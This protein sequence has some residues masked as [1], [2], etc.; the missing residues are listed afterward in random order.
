MKI[1]FFN[2]E[3]YVNFE[4][5]IGNYELRLLI[6]NCGLVTSYRDY[7]Y[8]R[9]L[10]SEGREAMDRKALQE[11]DDFHPDLVAYSTTWP[12]ESLSP[13]V[14]GEIRK[15]G[16]PVYTHAWDTHIEAAPHEREWFENCSFF[17]VA[18]SITNF[19]HY[20]RLAESQPDIRGCI[21][22]GG[23]N[24]FTDLFTKQDIPKVHDV[25][26]LGSNE[27]QRAELMNYL[28]GK[29]AP[30]GISLS[31]F[32]GLVD[33]TKK[34]PSNRLSDKWVSWER[35]VQIINQSKILLS[36]QTDSARC[37][38]KGKIFQ[39]MACGAFCLCDLNTEINRIIPPNCLVYYDDFE[40][41][42][43][44]MVYYLGH[45]DERRAIAEAAYHWFHSTFGYQKFWSKFLR[46][47]IIGDV[48]LPEPP[49]MDL[50]SRT[51]TKRQHLPVFMQKGS[52]HK[53]GGYLG[54]RSFTP[55]EERMTRS[56]ERRKNPVPSRENQYYEYCLKNHKPYF[57]KVMW[58]LQGVPARHAYMQLLVE[59]LCK[60]RG[61]KPLHIL[62]IGSWAGGSAITWAEAIKKHNQGRGRVVCI[63]PWKLYFRSDQY[64]DLPGDQQRVYQEMSAALSAGQVF[65]LFMHNIRVCKHED[66]ILPFK[67]SSDEILPLFGEGRFDLVFIDGDH[68]Y[69][70]VLEDIR[71][72]SS[73]VVEGGFLCGDDLELQISQADQNHAELNKHKDYILDPRTKVNFHPGVSL[74]VGEIF[75]T[76]SVWEGFWAMRKRGRGW[77]MVDLPKALPGQL[78]IPEH[79][80]CQGPP[81]LMKEDYKGYNIVQY[82]DQYYGLSRTLGPIDLTL[83]EEQI[84]RRHQSA[85]LCV[86]GRFLEE[87]EQMIDQMSVP[88]STNDYFPQGLALM[89]AGRFQEAVPTFLRA[90]EQSP[91]NPAI[92]NH[93]GVA[94]YR[95]GNKADAE[96]SFR[97]AIQVGPD[98]VDARVSLAE[99][100][101]QGNRY[102]EAVNYLKQA[103]QLAPQDKEVLTALGT[104]GMSLRDR[105]AIQAAWRS[106]AAID[107]NHPLVPKMQKALTTCPAKGRDRS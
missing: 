39:F 79:L 1:M 56:P 64:S 68:T 80:T 102:G 99:I 45:E 12:H 22:A 47:A 95:L 77:K 14:L 96:K 44:K 58:A 61:E 8:Q 60:G 36:S 85:G 33:S 70:R 34:G 30:Y 2:H 86:I 91:Q 82:L 43:E 49:I 38:I 103:A 54:S 42:L 28:G 84:L 15:R 57:G 21:F 18:D 7:V 19:L 87:T 3:Q 17:G 105:E 53:D 76:V 13:G 55:M 101:C 90:I 72:S 81:Q 52:M 62:E 24:V 32:G 16:I 6:L 27:G 65:D 92:H 37:Q 29:L 66:L 75:G 98:N 69:P 93:L 11:V 51:N 31:K 5:E 46:A 78:P 104:L 20:R 88:K 35:Y 50:D 83:V 41:C 89:Q 71:K 26:V 73:L 59:T 63:D 100:C 48:A 23:H 74:A 10:R 4:D 9:V 106:L 97:T 94:L 107:T 67:G 25:T 40:D